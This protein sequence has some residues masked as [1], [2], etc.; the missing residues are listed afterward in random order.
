MINYL[1][2]QECMGAGGGIQYDLMGQR[3]GNFKNETL[4]EDK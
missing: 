3:V 4:L 2:V 1:V